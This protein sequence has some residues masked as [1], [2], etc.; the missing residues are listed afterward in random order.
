M[1]LGWAMA[2][3]EILERLALLKLAAD[4]QN[5]TLN[6]AATSAYLARYDIDAHIARCDPGLPAQARPDAATMAETF[7]D[8][9]SFT[10]PDGGLFI[11][12]TF[13]DGFDA[14]AFMAEPLLPEAKVAYVPGATFFPVAPGAPPRPG[15]LLRRAGRPAGARHQR[16]GSAAGPRARLSPPCRCVRSGIG[17]GQVERMAR[18]S[19]RSGRRRGV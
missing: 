19:L 18:R 13:P 11:W 3:P 5:S 4:T 15:Q 2:S 6:M 10:R 1:R 7:P 17:I 9:V 14:A 8:D 12:L 16:A